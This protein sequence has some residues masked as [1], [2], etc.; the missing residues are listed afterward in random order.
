MGGHYVPASIK[1]LRLLF[2]KGKVQ[3]E[4]LGTLLIHTQRSAVTIRQ[5]WVLPIPGED[6]SG[7]KNF[8]ADWQALGTATKVS[9]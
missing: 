1:A 7:E 4:E 3:S 6:R 9:R 5:S 8:T 2:N